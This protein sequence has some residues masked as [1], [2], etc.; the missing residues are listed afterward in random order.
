MIE[1]QSYAI[2]GRCSETGYMLR[3]GARIWPSMETYWYNI[4]ILSVFFWRLNMLTIY[5]ISHLRVSVKFHMYA[6]YMRQNRI[7]KQ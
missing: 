5:A 6:Q 4:C 3:Y 1:L 2:C 7:I